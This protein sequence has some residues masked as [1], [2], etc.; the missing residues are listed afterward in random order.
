[1][2]SPLPQLDT[3]LAALRD[4]LA[5]AAPPPATD[6]A[7]AAAIARSTRAGRRRGSSA[8]PRLDGWMAWPLGLAAVITVLS[9]VIR[10]VPAPVA[11]DRGGQPALQ[12][13]PAAT[14]M[15]VVPMAEL[16]RA[17]DALV[18]PA[19]LSRL[20]LAQFGLPINPARAADA[21]DT[22][23]LVRPDGAVLAV[24]FIN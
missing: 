23:L 2:T 7:I 22:E 13:A 10:A 24:R 20:S 6:L 21:I 4:S 12:A 18:I 3:R 9:F 14:F 15:P 19:R 17:S 5:G 16:E 1:M 8:A 11:A